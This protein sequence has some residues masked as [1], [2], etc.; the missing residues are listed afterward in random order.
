[1]DLRSVL[2][3][4]AVIIIIY[5][6]YSYFSS[7]GSTKAPSIR[8]AESSHTIHGSSIPGGVSDNYTYSI[9]FY[10][11]NWN[12][13]Y[14]E[15]KMILGRHDDNKNP[16]PSISFAPSVNNINVKV[17]YHTGSSSSSASD[18]HTCTIENVPL[19][20]WTNVIISVSNR[21]LDVYLDGKLVRTCVLP[22]VP[23]SATG[24][25]IK[26]TGNG[27]FS[28]YTSNFEFKTHAINPREAYN[29]YKNGYGGGGIGSFFN[30][31]RIKLAFL[32]DNKEVNAV[33]I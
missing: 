4:I 32:E 18:V 12:Y 28:G 26:L 11:N 21:A 29:I 5:L 13:R 20:A 10:V 23:T 1:M 31:Y 16:A 25:Q 27:G 9:W 33:E 2:I 24:N 8:N 3:G 6:V 14:G 30:K 19:Q 22:G 17:G 7:D 15:E